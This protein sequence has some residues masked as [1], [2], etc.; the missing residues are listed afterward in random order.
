M[1][2]SKF[3]SRGNQRQITAQPKDSGDAMA[4]NWECVFEYGDELFIDA[5]QQVSVAVDGGG[6]RFVAEAVLDRF[7]RYAGGDQQRDMCVTQ[8][9][10]PKP[11]HPSGVGRRLPDTREEVV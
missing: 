6:D 4:S 8:I 3:R 2:K 9:V 1:T 7:H 10:E 11:S 5:G